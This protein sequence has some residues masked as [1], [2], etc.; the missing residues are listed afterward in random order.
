MRGWPRSQRHFCLGK[1]IQSDCGLIRPPPVASH[2]EETLASPASKQIS[3]YGLGS[4]CHTRKLE[5][6]G[7]AGWG[8]GGGCMSLFRKARRGWGPTIKGLYRASLR[9]KGPH[10]KVTGL[11]ATCLSTAWPPFPENWRTFPFANVSQLHT[12]F[13]IRVNLRRFSNAQ[14]SGGKAELTVSQLLI[15][16][17]PPLSHLLNEDPTP[18]SLTPPGTFRSLTDPDTASDT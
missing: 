5:E 13:R 2:S 3:F 8:R 17:G 14:K 18:P 10:N 9:L 16:T 7:W 11:V 15:P 12:R 4:W 1:D 6:P